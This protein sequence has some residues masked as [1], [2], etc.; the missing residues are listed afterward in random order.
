MHELG[1]LEG[2]L[3]LPH[4]KAGQLHAEINGTPVT[5]ADFSRLPTR[6][7]FIAFMPQ[8]EF[9]D[10]L[11]REASRSPFFRLVLEA[12]V[13]H[14]VEQDGRVV[15]VVA[16]TP[17]GPL[18]IHGTLVV[19]ADGRQSVLRRK[20]G[21]SVAELGS[22]SDVLWMSLSHQAA[23]PVQAMG[24]VGPRQG[25]VMI[26][27]GT[28]WQCGYVVSKGSF[29]DIKAAG[30]PAFRAALAAVAPFPPERFDEI[31]DWDNV[32]L[33]SIR[34]DR[35]KEWWKPGLLCIGDAAHAMSPIGGVGVNLAI[36]DAVAAAN[37]LAVPLRDGVL[38]NHHLMA[39]Q[40]RRSFP[41]AATQKLQLMMRRKRRV[42]EDADSK[43]AGP[44]AFMR[45]IAQW[46]LLARLAGRLIGLGFR[47]EHV[48]PA[49]RRP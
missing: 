26:D 44:P 47:P 19:G 32:S 16:R 18:S 31:K 45:R 23:D 17:E 25:F 7:R 43:P 40:K 39:V 38:R 29:D 28:F 3:A 33:L 1:L 12:G 14:V 37:I 49:M 21:L 5:I 15:G 27:R 24:H 20:A 11:A 48:A 6:C 46:P 9:L 22:P 41:T 2:L 8:W 34:I 42:N 35:L 36:Q 13:E 30:L 4:Q 10:Y